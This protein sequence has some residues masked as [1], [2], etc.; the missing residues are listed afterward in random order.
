MKVHYNFENLQIKNPVLTTG[1][2][3]GI[4]VGHKFIIN[5]LNEIAQDID[6]ESALVTFFP[7]PRQVLYPEMHVVM[8]NSQ[9]EKIEVMRNTGL[10]H[11][12]IINFTL[13]FSKTSSIDFIRK[14]LVGKVGVK[15]VVIGYDHNFGHN[16]E[17][18]FDYLYQLGQYYDFQVE[19][20]VAQDVEHVSVSSTKI[21]RALEEGDMR[22]VNTYLGH[23]YI[24]IGKVEQGSRFGRK[25]GFRTARIA[26]DEEVKLFPPAGVFAVLVEVEGKEYK[27][28]VDICPLEDYH[29]P[30]IPN[31]NRKLNVHIFNFDKEIYNEFVKISFIEK[32]RDRYNFITI[33]A[34]KD[35]LKIDKQ[36]ALNILK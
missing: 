17:G 27:G 36:I 31:K 24:V 3:D 9:R 25:I 19:E 8:I 12:I 26:A 35:Q 22:K 1:S 15:Y 2:F 10:D 30:Q 13:E 4:H 21:R 33:N 32:I 16:K 29:N 11:L 7:H 28:M 34:L 5:R 20:I 18:N 14:Y 23:N 6:G